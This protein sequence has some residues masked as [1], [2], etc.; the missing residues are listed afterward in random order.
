VADEYGMIYGSDVS[1]DV[2]Y[3]LNKHGY[4]FIIED[5]QISS[6]SQGECNG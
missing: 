6:I 3:E 5:G 2:L 1:L 4:E